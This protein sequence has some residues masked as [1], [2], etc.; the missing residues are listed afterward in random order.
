MT[1]IHWPTCSD[2]E[3]PTYG[4]NMG[5]TWAT[6]PIIRLMDLHSILALYMTINAIKDTQSMQVIRDLSKTTA[7]TMYDN[8]GQRH[9]LNCS[10]D[11]FNL[12]VELT[13]L[14]LRNPLT[15]EG[16][17]RHI[18]GPYDV[19]NIRVYANRF[20]V[21]NTR[22]NREYSGSLPT[23]AIQSV[24]ADRTARDRRQT[25]ARHAPAIDQL[26]ALAVEF[27]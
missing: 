1:L 8:S 2:T 14:M 3:I 25:D 23:I 11:L 13:E 19:L 20:T 7:L 17:D 12:L 21:Y 5:R 10:Q 27:G 6:Q 16:T 15:R 4:L 18:T 9:R 22:I 26:A 24:T